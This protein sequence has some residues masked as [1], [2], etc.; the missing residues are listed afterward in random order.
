[1]TNQ[2]IQALS[3]SG[4]TN[5]E[6]EK[7]NGKPLTQEQQKTIDRTRVVSRLMERRKAKK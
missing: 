4:A 5:K 2:Q 7:A 1:M 3:F 6:I